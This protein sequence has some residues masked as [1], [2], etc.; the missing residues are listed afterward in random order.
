MA[1]TD[2]QRMIERNT[3]ITRMTS[4][5]ATK[6]SQNLKHELNKKSRGGSGS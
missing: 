5:A 1:K 6:N 3:N 2:Y 4:G